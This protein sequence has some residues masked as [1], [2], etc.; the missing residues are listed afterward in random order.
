[1]IISASR[2]TDIPARFSDWFLGRLR[3]GFVYVRNPMNP[4]QVGKIPLNTDVVDGIVLWTKNPLPMLDKLGELSAYPFYFQFTLTSYR[5]DVEA[6]LP[7]KREVLIPAFQKLSDLIGPER[8]V[9]RYDPVFLN[10]AYSVAH[11]V[12]HFEETAKRLFKHTRRCVISFMDFYRK[13]VNN[14]KDLNVKPFEAEDRRLLSRSLADIARCYGLE[15]EACAEDMDLSRY[16]VARARCVDEKLLEKFGRALKI[17]K[18]KNQRAAC[19]C[20]ESID[21]GQYD[22]CQNACKYC[23]ANRSPQLAR[24]NFSKHDPRSP[25]ICGRLEE[26]DK[27]YERKAVSNKIKSQ[28]F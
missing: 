1:M 5:A 24:A 13:T 7:S 27:V 2:R 8:V 25:L 17:P 28:Q 10:A 26:A 15:L 9:W 6:N 3:E 23:Y 19:G 11:H 12:K 16:G 21:I 4:R 20:V 14:I 22:T 18:D